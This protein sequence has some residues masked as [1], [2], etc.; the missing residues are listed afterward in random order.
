MNGP[1]RSLKPPTGVGFRHV[2][3]LFAVLLGVQSVWLLLAEL[4]RSGIDSLPID[5]ASAAVAVKQRGLAGAGAS[6]GVIRGDLW[7]DS[8]FTYADLLWKEDASSAGL[9]P[10]LEGAR[11]SLKY[12]IDCAPHLSAVWL[13]LAGL[14]SRYRSLNI[15]A[16][17]A[18]KTSYYTGPSEQDL[19][20][21]RLRVAA[22]SDFLNDAEIRQFVR[23]DLRVLISRN[24][25]PAI[26]E[27]INGGSPTGKA[28]IKQAVSQMSAPASATPQTAPH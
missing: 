27:A 26:D 25:K 4:T 2:I 12:A 20:V 24:Q 10:E 7:A 1:D 3:L 17:Q 6:F 14:A 5:A 15:N 22:Q 21:P 16:T 8:A 28:F 18:L 11:R 13:M 23:R 19:I 9:P